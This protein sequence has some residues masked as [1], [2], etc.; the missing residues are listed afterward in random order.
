MNSFIRGKYYPIVLITFILAGVAYWLIY[1]VSEM[2]KRF[3]VIVLVAAANLALWH[4]MKSG[5]K[6]LLTIAIS[7]AKNDGSPASIFTIWLSMIVHYAVMGFLF[8][9]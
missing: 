4:G 7:D 3:V 1:P 8:L 2:D 9:V 5:R 6:K